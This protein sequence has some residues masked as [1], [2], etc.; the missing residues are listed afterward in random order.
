MSIRQTWD[1]ILLSVSVNC[2]EMQCSH[3]SKG[4]KPLISQKLLERLNAKIHSVNTV[5]LSTPMIF[6]TQ[7]KGCYSH[8]TENA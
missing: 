6:D 7:R 2:S 5:G 3:V 8:F 4:P 1:P